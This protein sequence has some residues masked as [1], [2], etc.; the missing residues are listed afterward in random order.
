MGELKRGSKKWWKL[1]RTILRK[2]EKTSSIPSLKSPLD[3][4]W[5]K[6]DLEKARTF[7]EVFGGKFKLPVLEENEYSTLLVTGQAASDFA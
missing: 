1:S 6:D 3:G 2:P 4:H 5:V 7:A